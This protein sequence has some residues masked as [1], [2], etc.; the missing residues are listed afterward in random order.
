MHRTVFSFL[1][2]LLFL[3]CFARKIEEPNNIYKI[4]AQLLN[5]NDWISKSDLEIA[6]LKEQIKN[7]KRYYLLNNP[8]IYDV[9]N[10]NYEAMKD[11]TYDVKGYRNEIN[12]LTEMIDMSDSDSL[13]SLGENQTE[14]DQKINL[15]FSEFII[16][17]KEYLKSKEGLKRA[18]RRDLKKL[19][20]VK[21]KT[22]KWKN[23][24]FEISLDRLEL[25]QSITKFE[26][27]LNLM[28]FDNDYDNR[29]KIK[30]LSRRIQR[31][32]NR[33]NEIETYVD[34]L[35]SIAL[36]EIGGWVYV[37]GFREKKPDFEVKY[38]KYKKEYRKIIRN[39]SFE[40]KEI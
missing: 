3:N 12:E 29:K 33:L 7:Q 5:I 19:V 14:L 1:L 11:I 13:D 16:S 8:S 38:K 20:F 9:L 25:D 24:F 37:I 27:E 22:N 28:I 23:D 10:E 15:V 39:I 34:K 40:L 6:I 26:T 36:R 2:V 35:D 17:K 4:K 32:T 18:L 21:D 30:K 31:Y